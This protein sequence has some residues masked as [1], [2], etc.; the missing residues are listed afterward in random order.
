VVADTAVPPSAAPAAFVPPRVAVPEPGEPGGSVDALLRER[1][2]ATPDEVALVCGEVALTARELDGRVDRLARLLADRGAGPGSTVALALPRAADHVVAIFAVLRTGAAY[3]PLEPAH[4]PARL[5]ELVA[6]AG[7]VLLVTTAERRSAVA[8]GPGTVVL[9]DDPD[10]AAVLDGRAPAP[11]RPVPGPSS[12]DQ[13]AYV[14]YTSGSTG[15]PKGVVVGHRGLTAMY[16]NH[17]EEIFGPAGR[18]AGRRLRI[19]HTVSFSFD[20]SWEELF[21]LLAGHEVHVIDE[22]ARLEPVSL[23]AHYRAIGIDVV[24]V[25]PSY[26]RELIGAGLLDGA[27]PPAL[28]MLGGEAVPPELWTRLREQDGV[29]GYDLYGPTEF[30]INAM[31]APV[32]G[33]ATPCLGRPVRNAQA[34]VLDSGLR[35]VPAGAVGELYLSGDGVAHGYLNRAGLTAAAFVADP[36]SGHGR[37]MYR[38]GDLVRLRPDGELEYLGRADGQVKVRGFRIELGEVEAALAACPGVR[39]AAAAVRSDGGPARLVGYVIL[40]PGGAPADPRRDLRAAL[41]DRLPG[42]LVPADV[43]VVGSMPLTPN[44]K[45]D[46]AALPAPPRRAAGRAPRDDRERALCRLFA[47]VLE[48]DEVDPEEGFFDLGGDS[49]TAMRLVG[50]L[51]RELG[52]TVEVGTLMAR[53]S[54]A[55]LAAHLGGTG[56]APEAD[57]GRGHALPSTPTC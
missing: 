35:P 13:P 8:D 30:T 2:A 31:G 48:V 38:T 36:F 33:S 39:R 10:V 17:V 57:L 3:L 22:R 15:R 32:R 53:P 50:A 54:V 7:A 43:V 40:E 37:R 34:R 41:R 25:T 19:A 9:L 56:P 46:R 49:L 6:D 20:M 12:A 14:I 26:A 27:H 21:W 55:E 18:A 5:R 11:D 51:D 24:N 42:H 29:D 45:L 28:V 16:H 44:G 23:V 1:A 52:A 4:P 47:R